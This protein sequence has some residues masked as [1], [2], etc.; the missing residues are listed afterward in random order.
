MRILH[1]T[2]CHVRA[3]DGEN[4]YGVNPRAVLAGLLRDCADTD[5]IDLVAVTGD[6]ADDGSRAAYAV[7]LDLIGGFARARGAA[8]AY[9]PGNHDNDRAAFGDVL[10]AGHFD[11]AGRPVGAR[12]PGPERA[13][14]SEVGGYRVITLDSQVP[15][16]VH[17]LIGADQLAWL[18]AT[19]A[20]PAAA[21]SVVLLHH[22]PIGVDREPHRSYGLRNAADLAE[23]IAGSDVQ[24]I[25]CGHFHAQLAGRLGEVPVWAGPGIVTRYDLTE[26]S[27]DRAVRGASATVVDL[28]GLGS[29]LFHLLHARDPQAGQPLYVDDASGRTVVR[30]GG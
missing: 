17:G 21:G 12:A 15:G 1:L 24:A 28:G 2:D 7:A 19:L 4:S 16:Q 27:A 29:P 14:V 25:L 3:S 10:G 9:C 8:Q 20:A 6:V 22:P 13:A 26:V 18:R 11:P 30:Q 23:A 5:G